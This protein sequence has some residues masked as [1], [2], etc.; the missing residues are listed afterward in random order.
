M[1]L[2]LSTVQEVP[3]E[4]SR[5]SPFSLYTEAW[6][7]MAA[8]LFVL[9]AFL[10][11]PTLI[12][13]GAF[14]VAVV[15]FS[16]G[17]SRVIL[18]RLE[19]RRALSESRAFVGETV[20]LTLALTNHKW[21]PVPWLRLD[22]AFPEEMAPAGVTL[23]PASQP[24]RATFTRVTALGPFETVRW[25]FS[26]FCHRRGHYFFGPA[27]LA[28]GD[29][30]GLFARHGV[31]A[32]QLR[33]IVYP[34]VFPLDRLGFPPKDPLGLQ[35]APRSLFEDPTRPAGARPYR[36]EDPLR[37]VHWK[38][39][40]RTQALHVHVWEPTEAHIVMV[41]LNTATF[42]RYWEGIDPER[43]EQLIQVAASIALHV[44]EAKHPVGLIANATV[45]RSDQPV[46]V[47]VG[48]RPDHMRRILEVLAA[49]TGFATMP[50]E[51]LIAR[52][53]SR[54]P[55]GS[56][57]V[58]VTAVVTQ[59][60]LTTLWRL[61]HVGRRIVLVSLDTKWQPDEETRSKM[62][63]YTATADSEVVSFSGGR[64]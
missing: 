45:P 14:L 26:L 40:A 38:V 41:F 29:V 1:P 28:A 32:D 17:W 18:R 11:S 12:A 59:P 50:I 23:S 16:W 33:L 9:G 49:V 35:R 34:R 3:V 63:I 5:S 13:L 53:A 48:R 6:G 20:T 22:D 55:W 47:P 61:H 52:E 51:R 4:P 10:R 30:F 60:L 15:L 27:H 24:G 58:V 43:L 56:T 64:G 44:W 42:A 62:T 57:I 21:V 7:W 25:S 19:Y 31:V 46:R 54:L 39:T 2:L 36:P 8:L 37:R